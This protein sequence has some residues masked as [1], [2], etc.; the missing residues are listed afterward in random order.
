MPD[1]LIYLIG[2][3]IITILIKTFFYP[4]KVVIRTRV[5]YILK[6][7][8]FTN[9]FYWC[10]IDIDE[11][12]LTLTSDMNFKMLRLNKKDFDKVNYARKKKIDVTFYCTLHWFRQPLIT[13]IIVHTEDKL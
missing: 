6:D 8:W 10:F 1:W 9:S 5:A 4:A 11:T 2:L 3:V 12:N 13:K 7:V